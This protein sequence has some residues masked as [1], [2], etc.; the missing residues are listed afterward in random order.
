MWGYVLLAVLLLLVVLLVWRR[1]SSVWGSDAVGPVRRR[2]TAVFGP[3]QNGGESVVLFL[4][5]TRLNSCPVILRNLP[6]VLRF[7][8]AAGPTLA[9]L[10]RG[11]SVRLTAC[12]R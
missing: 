4:I 1:V 2:V 12:C 7:L 8:A 10:G 6:A 11:S 9:L 5:G 3:E